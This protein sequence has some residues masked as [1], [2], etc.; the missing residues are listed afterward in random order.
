MASPGQAPIAAKPVHDPQ[1]PGHAACHAYPMN[2]SDLYSCSRQRP[3][4]S[5]LHPLIR[6][7]WRTTAP[8]LTNTFLSY[9]NCSR[10][11]ADIVKHSPRVAGR[12]ASAP[13]DLLF[14]DERLAIDDSAQDPLSRSGYADFLHS[15]LF[16][17]REQ[18]E[19][20]DGRRV[21]A[22]IGRQAQMATR[23][24]TSAV[25]GKKYTTACGW[26]WWLH[27]HCAADDSAFCG[28][29]GDGWP[30]ADVQVLTLAKPE[31]PLRRTRYPWCMQTEL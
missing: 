22:C 1:R 24:N 8:M 20:R 21:S 17:K 10:R 26:P 16:P 29:A 19:G 30:S 13:K 27:W 4:W 7:H 11:M 28:L 6:S 9:G 25:P 5:L 15:L 23:A 3:S 14:D 12:I 31:V 2:K 18:P